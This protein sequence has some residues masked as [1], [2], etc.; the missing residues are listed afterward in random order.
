MEKQTLSDISEL[1]G[2]SVFIITRHTKYTEI[3]FYTTRSAQ[4]WF[5]NLWNHIILFQ[6]FNLICFINILIYHSCFH[7]MARWLRKDQINGT[8]RIRVF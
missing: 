2:A 7:S 6:S 4:W 5:I 8:G 3:D 1:N